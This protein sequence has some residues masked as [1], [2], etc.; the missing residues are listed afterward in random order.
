MVIVD[1]KIKDGI[2]MFLRRSPILKALRMCRYNTK[3]IAQC[4]MLRAIPE[5]TGH[6]HWETTCLVLPQQPPGQQ[7]TKQQ[8]TNAPALLAIL[9]AVVVRRYNTKHIVQ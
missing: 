1:D 7:Q 3:C 4:I 2:K 6:C 9:T 8:G 5:A